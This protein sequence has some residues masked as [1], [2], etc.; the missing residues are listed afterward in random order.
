MKL[1]NLAELPAGRRLQD[2]APQF[3]DVRHSIGPIGTPCPICPSCRKPFGQARKPR[4]GITLFPETSPIPFGLFYRLCGACA[5]GYRAEGDQ[6]EA[7]LAAISN[8]VTGAE[9]QA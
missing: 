3:Q 6:R 1:H 5:H 7:A 4:L 2:V 9:V 8:F